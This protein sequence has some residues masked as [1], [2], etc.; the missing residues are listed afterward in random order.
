[1]NV[2]SIEA[3]EIDVFAAR[4]GLEV[5]V[6]ERPRPVGDFGRYYAVIHTA[7]RGH[8]V[9]VK[10][11]VFLRGDCGEGATP[12]SATADAARVY[13]FKIPV[14]DAGSPGRREITAPRL[15]HPVT[16]KAEP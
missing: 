3:V 13:S 1:V 12:W 9:D 16:E 7:G 4:H 2:R 10:D 15:F 6:V 14:I 5:L 8:N 11:G